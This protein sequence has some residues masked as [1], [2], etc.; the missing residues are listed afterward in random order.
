[1]RAVLSKWADEGELFQ[2]YWQ[3]AVATANA[4][5]ELARE[6]GT[7]PD[8]AFLAGL[9][10]DL[11]RLVQSV[12]APASVRAARALALTED[13]DPFDAESRLVG[14]THDDIGAAVA[15]RWLLPEPIIA[16]I[17][18]HHMPSKAL[19]PGAAL[20]VAVVHVADA[21][22]HAMDLAGDLAEAVPPIDSL[23]WRLAGPTEG[24]MPR[25]VERVTAGVALMTADF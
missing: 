12:F 23:A 20:V 16:A 7:D 2:G 10:H 9:L 6:A 4:A 11:G 18:L 17:A 25:I 19:E 8:E 15:R 3:H 14:R 13:V 21:I 1:M 5:R 24:A 22:V